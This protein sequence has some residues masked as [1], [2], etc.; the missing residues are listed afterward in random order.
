M[1][2]KVLNSEIAD[3]VVNE[4]QGRARKKYNSKDLFG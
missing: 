1:Q 4:V 2:K 3:L